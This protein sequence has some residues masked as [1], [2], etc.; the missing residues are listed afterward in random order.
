M[1]KERYIQKSLTAVIQNKSKSNNKDFSRRLKRSNIE[2]HSKSICTKSF[3]IVLTHSSSIKKEELK[4]L[5]YI[6]ICGEI[7]ETEKYSSEYLMQ[8]YL[9]YGTDFIKKLEGS[10]IILIIDNRNDSISIITDRYNT[11]KL[12]FVKI[13]NS[14]LLSTS[15]Y[16]FPREFF[17]IDYAGL[18]SYL[19]NNAIYDN[20]TLLEGV[21]IFEKSSIHQ[22]ERNKITARKYWEYIFTAEYEGRKEN[23]LEQEMYELLVKSVKKRIDQ[24]RKVYLSLSGGWDSRGLAALLS[25]N[26]INFQNVECFT[27]NYGNVLSE[28][29]ADIAGRIA[30][31]SGYRYRVVQSY[32]GDVLHCIRANANQGSG[33][34]HFCGETDAWEELSDEFSSSQENVLFTGQLINGS[35]ERFYGDQNRALSRS[36]IYT[37]SLL[38]PYIHLFEN[39]QAEKILKAWDQLYLKLLNKLTKYSDMTDVLDYIDFDQ[40]VPHVYNQWREDFQMPFIDVANPYYDYDF[41]DFNS[42]LPSKYRHSKTMLVKC[43]SKNFP[44][45]FTIPRNNPK[46]VKRVNW[47]NELILQ[48]EEIQNFLYNQS[49]MLDIIIPPGNIV[50]F[51][52]N[53]KKDKKYT[54]SI[55]KGV[56]KLMYKILPG[57]PK[58]IEKLPFGKK[59][60]GKTGNFV[61]TNMD[62]FIE[63]ILILRYFLKN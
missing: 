57:Y 59:I 12:Y 47:E 27:Y 17:N 39:D 6:F 29:E 60:I 19:I 34:A 21:R 49:S 8:D 13:D 42:K 4:E 58:F 62:Y 56:H 43:L 7:Y 53:S 2:T 36:E 24:K 16:N 48:K 46:I 37:S 20:H 61:N 63:K 51:I 52:N 30:K 40:K 28:S 32:R 41:I 14:Y 50:H 18:A 1:P 45:Y 15:I 11:K 44:E 31:K 26:E 55:A 9:R 33:K 10:F 23:E 35:F 25:S 22:I 54:K 5:V 38:K 3:S